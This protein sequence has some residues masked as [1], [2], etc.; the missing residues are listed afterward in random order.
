MLAHDFK[1]MP[2][3]QVQSPAGTDMML[4]CRYCMKTP[5]KARQDGCAMRELEEN[6]IIR[7]SVFNPEGVS[8][9]HGRVCVTCEGPI[10]GHYLRRNSP[11][12]WCHATEARF[13]E[14]INNCVFDVEGIKVPQEPQEPK[15]GIDDVSV[16]PETNPE[17]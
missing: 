17:G 10:M 6:G 3:G 1:D 8:Y 13:S 12:Y 9:F 5:S 2:T 14:G 7:L 11:H 16:V 15:N 4:R